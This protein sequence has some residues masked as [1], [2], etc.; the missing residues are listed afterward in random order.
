MIQA[1]GATTNKVVPHHV[2][3]I[4][5]GNRR[6]AK[7][8]GLPSFEGHRRGFDIAPDIIRHSQEMGIHTLTLWAFS[9]ENWNRS[10]KEI[11]YLMRLYEILID[12]NLAEAK[13]KEA[14]IY[15]LGRKD[16]I[17]QALAKKIANAEEQT[18]QY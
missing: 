5:D 6:W 12:K 13:E 1:D 4:P 11:D 10:Q 14:R 3:L 7:N 15:H 16:R 8:K 9:T 17:P 18:S 2:A